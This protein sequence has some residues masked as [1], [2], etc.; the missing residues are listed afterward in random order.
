[1]TMWWIYEVKSTGIET[2]NG[3]TRSGVGI[4]PSPSSLI[5]EIYH[6]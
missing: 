1:M 3:A 4:P 6:L 5:S 2:G